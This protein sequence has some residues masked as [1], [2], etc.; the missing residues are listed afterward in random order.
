MEAMSSSEPV[1]NPVCIERSAWRLDKL[2]YM[3][4]DVGWICRHSAYANYDLSD[5][6]AYPYHAGT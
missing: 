6:K 4:N 5:F 2:V 1:H 3:S